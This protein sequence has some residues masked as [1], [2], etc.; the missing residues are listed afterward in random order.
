[1]NA[2]Q[3]IRGQRRRRFSTWGL[4]ASRTSTY[5]SI[6]EACCVVIPRLE[7]VPAG[8]ASLLWRAYALASHGYFVPQMNYIRMT[9]GGIGWLCAISFSRVAAGPRS[10]SP[11]VAFARRHKRR[12]VALLWR[13]VRGQFRADWDHS[14]QS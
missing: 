8:S 7:S 2:R 10:S 4:P 13:R 14:R 12:A 1:V 3:R 6:S 5:L 11:P 9:I